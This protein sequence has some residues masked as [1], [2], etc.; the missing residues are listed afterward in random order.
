MGKKSK[1]AFSLNDIAS[2]HG[3][4][5][6][7]SLT[8]VVLVVLIFVKVNKKCHKKSGP[9]L[10]GGNKHVI[11]K[12]HRKQM[13]DGLANV[14]TWTGNSVQPCS[15]PGVIL[16]DNPHACCE[17]THPISIDG[18]KF[19]VGTYTDKKSGFSDTFTCE[20]ACDEVCN[21]YGSDGCDVGA[22]NRACGMLAK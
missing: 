5:V 22:C 4:M 13:S 16:V 21:G 2:A 15:T 18:E 11:G 10:S 6:I 14:T 8:L 9:N 20:E 7:L 12:L 1:F 19:C 17:G 3:L